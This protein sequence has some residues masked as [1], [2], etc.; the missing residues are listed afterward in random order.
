MHALI[1]S[2][3]DRS[4]VLKMALTLRKVD[5]TALEK[6]YLVAD[7]LIAPS[8]NDTTPHERSAQESEITTP[9]FVV[10]PNG[11][12]RTTVQYGSA[13]QVNLL[14]L[15]TM[16]GSNFHAV[17]VLQ[18]RRLLKRCSLYRGN[19]FARGPGLPGAQ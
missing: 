11:S 15:A 5:A 9:L 6:L 17:T 12:L 13:E 7:I 2:G 14:R 16:S 4:T 8:S 18:K 3:P 1:Q 10:T 19:F